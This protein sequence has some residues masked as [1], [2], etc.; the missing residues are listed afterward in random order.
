MTRVESLQDC[1]DTRHAASLIKILD[2]DSV[3]SEETVEN[4]HLVNQLCALAKACAEDL[5]Y[6]KKNKE[7][8]D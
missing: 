8:Q 5:E 6:D 1:I 7:Q 4:S 2:T 3:I